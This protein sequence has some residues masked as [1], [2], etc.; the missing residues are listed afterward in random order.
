MSTGPLLILTLSQTCKQYLT[1]FGL[2]GMEGIIPGGYLHRLVVAFSAYCILCDKLKP[3]TGY[4]ATLMCMYLELWLVPILNLPHCI[5]IPN[6]VKHVLH[7]WP[8]LVFILGPENKPWLGAQWP[9]PLTH[10][11]HGTRAHATPRREYKGPIKV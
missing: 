4:N 9:Q 8:Q 1:L 3:G 5:L 11:Q 2:F 6:I 7:V 10:A